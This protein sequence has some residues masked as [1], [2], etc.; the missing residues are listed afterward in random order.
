MAV[1]YLKVHFSQFEESPLQ[2]LCEDSQ[3][4][5]CKAFTDLSKHANMVGGGRP[6][7]PEILA[8]NDPLPSK[9]PN[10]Y[11]FSLVAHQ[12]SA[13]TPTKKSSYD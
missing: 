5:S 12:P 2:S 9:M 11:L 3:Q 4:R 10:F 6:F 7:L 8:E 13:V 1:F